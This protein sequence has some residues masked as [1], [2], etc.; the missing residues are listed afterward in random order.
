MM[1]SSS[2]Q[3]VLVGLTS[4]G[5]GCANPQYSGVYTRVAA[6]ESW[7]SSYTNGSVSISTSS[8]STTSSSSILT[9]T[10][11]T[12]FTII[13]SHVNTVR[14]SIFNIFVFV[15]FNLLLEFFY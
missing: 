2:N 7:I 14:T 8:V 12:A 4:Y 5:D 6:Y 11:A 10:S 15:L 9:I 1:F 3:W 13:Y